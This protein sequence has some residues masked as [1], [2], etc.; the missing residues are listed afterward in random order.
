MSQT[1]PTRICLTSDISDMVAIADTS[2]ARLATGGTCG[3]RE[4]TSIVATELL[5]ATHERHDAE[6]RV[7]VCGVSAQQSAT[8]STSRATPATTNSDP[9]VG[10]GGNGLHRATA[11]VNGVQQHRDHHRSTDEDGASASAPNVRHSRQGGKSVHGDSFLCA[12]DA[13]INCLR[14]RCAFHRQLLATTLAPVGHHAQIVNCQPPTDRRTVGTH[15]SDRRDAIATV[16]QSCGEQLGGATTVGRI[17]NQQPRAGVDAANTVLLNYGRHP[18][19]PAGLL[20][21]ELKTSAP[22]VEQLTSQMADTLKEAKKHLEQAQAQQKKA[23]DTRRREVVFRVGDRVLVSSKLFQS[24]FN[25][26]RPAQKLH[27]KYSGPY[28]VLARVGNNAYKLELPK[29]V[30]SHPVINVSFLKL[31]KEN[32]F[33]ERAPP[34]PPPPVEEAAGPEYVVEEVLKHKRAPGR[35]KR[36]LYLVK[37]AGYS[38][39]DSTWEPRKHLDDNGVI[40]EALQKYLK[41]HPSAQ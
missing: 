6:I 15:Q 3:C 13:V 38:N 5:L 10:I 12:R 29:S 39:E 28:K 26:Q 11:R 2:H 17:C 37:W 36:W 14:S 32:E 21:G 33:E 16:C 1:P 34:P 7:V 41:K 24:A 19:T 35:G 8:V 20:T 27:A 22:A 25:Q 9:A 4:N 30:K 31:F 40:C 18:M 23:A